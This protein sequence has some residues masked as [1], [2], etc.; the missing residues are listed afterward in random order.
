MRHWLRVGFRESRRAQL[1][2]T[3]FYPICIV[4]CCVGNACYANKEKRCI[5]T[6]HSVSVWILKLCSSKQPHHPGSQGNSSGTCGCMQ[7]AHTRDE[8]E[9][10]FTNRHK[11]AVPVRPEGSA[12]A[13][14][15]LHHRG[16]H[17][18][19]SLQD[20][21]HC[22]ASDTRTHASQP[23]S[24]AAF[25][26]STPALAASRAHKLTLP[27]AACTLHEPSTTVH[28]RCGCTVSSGRCSMRCSPARPSS[29]QHARRVGALCDV[30]H[31]DRAACTQ[32]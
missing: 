8:P 12:K 17:K 27:G 7:T 14:L 10:C 6:A 22:C 15:Q 20:L 1:P 18:L 30:V 5:T 26:G 16:A 21:R 32:Q 2:A 28:L 11:R 31:R 13:H 24:P 3:R 23:E 4:G 19:V 25:H 29:V 9:A